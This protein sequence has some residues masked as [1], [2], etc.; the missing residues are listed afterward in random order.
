MKWRARLKGHDF[1]LEWLAARLQAGS[2]AVEHDEDAYYLTSTEFEAMADSGDVLKHAHSIVAGLNGLLRLHGYQP[3]EAN[4]LVEEV[5]SGQRKRSMHSSASLSFRSK[6]TATA[7]VTGPN[8]EVRE[9]SLERPDDAGPIAALLGADDKVARALRVFG[10]P[11]T[12]TSLYHG[13][14]IVE[15]EQGGELSMLKVGWVPTDQIKRFKHTANSVE[16][17]GDASRHG[18]TFDSPAR[19]MSL[20]EA[21]TLVGAILKQWLESKLAP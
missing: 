12:W 11:R 2:V 18:K 9:E 20:S 3:V 21:E 4:G 7:T 8:G 14:E 1:D 10:S 17:G 19:P 16:A 13:Y 5:S 6:L 15:E